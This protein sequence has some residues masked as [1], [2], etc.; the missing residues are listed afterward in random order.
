MMKEEILKEILKVGVIAVVRAK[1]A[2]LAV[3]IALAVANGGIKPVE[4]TMTVPGAME[5]IKEV[6]QK[7]VDKV[8]VGAGTVLDTETARMAILAGAE[9]VVSPILNL[10]VIE[11]CKRYSKVIIPGAYTPTE[12]LTAWER[13]ADIVKVF[14]A[15]TGGPQYFRDIHGPLPQI[16]LLPTG[17]VTL[18]NAADF[19][20]AGACAIAVGSNLVDK[21]AVAEGKFEIITEEAIKFREVVE[22][23]RST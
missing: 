20:R 2:D 14:P 23:A 12:I 7:L 11:L 16:R 5:A 18:E 6:S 3:K 17:G 9:F 21:K 13:G 8:I 19:I 4:I 22:K 15:T 10:K 1:S